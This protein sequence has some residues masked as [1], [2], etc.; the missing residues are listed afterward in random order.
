MKI[1][2]LFGLLLL[3]AVIFAVIKILKS[4]AG[5]GEKLLWIALVAVLPLIGV[6]IWYFAGPGDKALRL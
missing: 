2:G 1:S 5:D 4:R 3:L 6:I